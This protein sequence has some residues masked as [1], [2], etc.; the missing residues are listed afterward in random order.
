MICQDF[1][2]VIRTIDHL[3]IEGLRP[4]L[5]CDMPRQLRGTDVTDRSHAV[6]STRVHRSLC[7]EFLMICLYQLFQPLEGFA[8]RPVILIGSEGSEQQRHEL[9]RRTLR[10]GFASRQVG[11]SRW[12][13]GLIKTCHILILVYPIKKGPCWSL[14]NFDEKNMQSVW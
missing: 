12:T 3:S 14:K 5:T 9:Q 10:M 8:G 2:H 6:H 13:D 11:D 4:C 1:R 7:R